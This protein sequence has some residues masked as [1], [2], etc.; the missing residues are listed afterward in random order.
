MKFVCSIRL[1]LDDSG[2]PYVVLSDENGLEL[3]DS[4]HDEWQNVDIWRVWYALLHDAV[5]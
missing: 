1:D 2:S 4:L 5:I 3:C